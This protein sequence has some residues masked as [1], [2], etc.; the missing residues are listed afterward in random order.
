[1]CKTHNAQVAVATV[2]RPPR[3]PLDQKAYPVPLQ[4]AQWFRVHMRCSSSHSSPL[5]LTHNAI[6]SDDPAPTGTGCS[7]GRQSLL[8]CNK[9]FV[10]WLLKEPCSVLVV[11]NGG[12]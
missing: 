10:S 7:P 9:Q 2:V 3:K 5:A 4:L 8:A 1:L 11:S 12:P 6:G